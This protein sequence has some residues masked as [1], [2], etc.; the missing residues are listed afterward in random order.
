MFVP[1]GK[2]ECFGSG[3]LALLTAPCG[4][5]AGT[6]EPVTA[7]RLQYSKGVFAAI[8][9]QPE[10]APEGDAGGPGGRIKKQ[11][12][13]QVQSRRGLTGL[14]CRYNEKPVSKEAVFGF[15][16][17]GVLC[18]RRR[19][20]DGPRIKKLPEWGSLGGR[21]SKQSAGGSTPRAARPYCFSLSF[22]YCKRRWR[23]STAA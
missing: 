8:Y 16:C 4:L 1:F 7:G 14:G 2:L 11:A 17:G 20:I 22:L 10:A 23:E 3:Q 5:A 12:S 19:G 9:V 18:G 13:P 15:G 21:S 6:P